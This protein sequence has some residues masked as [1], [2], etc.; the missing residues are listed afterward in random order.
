MISRY[1]VPEIDSLA[2]DLAGRIREIAAKTGFVPNV[3]LALAHRPDELRVFMAYHDVVME[4]PG[5]LSKAEREMIVVA[6]SA[7]RSCSYCVV[8]HGAILRI[9]AHDPRIADLIAVNHRLAPLSDR[10]HAMLDY[11]VKLSTH[12]EEVG[13]EDHAALREAGFD[14]EDLWD[15]ASVVAFFALSNR[16]ALALKI[17]PNQEFHLLGRVPRDA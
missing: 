10:H 6:T 3:F 16:L 9:R 5:G 8:A 13:D 14:D 11:A 17:A 12:P 1:P 4:S 7:T 15:I 2:P